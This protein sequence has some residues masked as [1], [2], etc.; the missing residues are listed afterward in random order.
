MLPPRDTEPDVRDRKWTFGGA[1]QACADT[2]WFESAG[3]GGRFRLNL[4]GAHREEGY[5]ME[6]RL[7]VRGAKGVWGAVCDDGWGMRES[8]VVCGQ[9]GLGIGVGY[10]TQYDLLHPY[11]PELN[12]LMDD[13]NCTGMESSLHDCEFIGGSLQNCEVT[14]T[15]G[16]RCSGPEL[17]GPYCIEQCPVGK[18]P[19]I[20]SGICQNCSAQCLACA[21]P[22]ASGQCTACQDPFFLMPVT[23]RKSQTT[24]DCQ[25]DCPPGLYGNLLTRRCQQCSRGCESCLNG[26]SGDTCTSCASDFLLFESACVSECPAG[27][28]LHVDGS[29]AC[30]K[31]CPEGFYAGE[32]E[33]PP[34]ASLPAT[35]SSLRC[36]KCASECLHCQNEVNNCTLCQRSHVL[37]PLDVKLQSVGSNAHKAPSFSC[38]SQCEN[39]FYPDANDVCR[40]C[41]DNHCDNCFRGGVYCMHCT[42]GYYVQ[43]GR[44]VRNCT[45][46]LYPIDG[47]C[48][49][50]CPDGFYG[51]MTTEKCEP[52]APGCRTCVLPGKCTGCYGG[53]FLLEGACVKE[54]REGYLS[55][56]YPRKGGL[57]LMGGP[58]SL[59]GRV[60]IY[61]EGKY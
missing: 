52:C 54:C 10:D 21:G 38:Q 15:V 56:T 6:G 40:P 8:D 11:L 18:Y 39:G 46:G 34:L 42:M 3:G 7:E 31:A 60:E 49:F 29:G 5:E 13:V 57:R 30:V 28:I 22:G 16:V 58:N 36:L 47:T 48:I 1:C 17:Q 51:N 23:V 26:I 61:H 9:L 2:G 25:T 33:I 37:Q 20:S 4:V 50:P 43:L 41:R 59:D 44:C 27:T 14:E 53:R 19:D 24:G 55:V 32:Q 12:I 45:S 35:T